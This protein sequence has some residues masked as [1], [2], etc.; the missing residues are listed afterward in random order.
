MRHLVMSILV[1]LPLAAFA[2]PQS[3]VRVDTSSGAQG[4][5]YAYG[6]PLAPPHIFSGVGADTLRLNR[7]PYD[8]TRSSVASTPVAVSAD[9]QSKHELCVAA[10]NFSKRGGTKEERLA[11]TAEVFRSSPLVDRVEVGRSS[12]WLY[13]KDG[14]EEEVLLPVEGTSNFGLAEL[15]EQLIAEFRMVVDRGGFVAFGE[16]YH[17]VTPLKWVPKTLELIARLD[18]G[19]MVSETE[20]KNTPLQ[21][22]RFFAD[23]L[24]DRQTR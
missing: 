16:G 6:V 20:I 11:L 9:C 18:R 24:A 1:A 2:V 13:W 14:E 12:L 10:S 17:V 23:V 22:K 21:N 4:L 7:L 15:H 19:E 3:A 8:P 5:V